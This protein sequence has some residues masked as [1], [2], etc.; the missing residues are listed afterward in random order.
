M[1]AKKLSEEEKKKRA[2]AKAAAKAAKPRKARTP[3]SHIV[4]RGG[5]DGFW[6]DVS[7]GHKTPKAARESIASQTIPG[8]Y[9][10]VRILTTLEAKAQTGLF[11]QPVGVAVEP[12]IAETVPDEPKEAMG[13]AS[14]Q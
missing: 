1:A 10:V 7:G 4:Q 2:E 9:R 11:L 13:T 8:T 12:T 14:S 5:V 6:V 3:S